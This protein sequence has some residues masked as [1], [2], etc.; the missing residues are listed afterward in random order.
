MRTFTFLL[1]LISFALV[2]A[3]PTP[4]ETKASNST[5]EDVTKSF[6]LQARQGGPRAQVFSHCT[7]PNTVALTF[8]DGPYLYTR[9]VAEILNAAG[10][11]GTF[12]VNGNNW[13][14]IYNPDLSSQLKFAYDTG[15]Q[16]ASH[17]WAHQN[18]ATLTWDQIHHQMWLVEQA[19]Q[20]ITGASVAFMRPPYGS[21]NNLV[22]EASYIRGQHVVYWDF[23]SGDSMGVS[24]PAQ[25]AR[26][27]TLAAT[28]PSTALSLQHE[29]HFLPHAISRLQTAGYNLVTVAQCLG[30]SPYRSVGSPG[31][32]DPSWA[33]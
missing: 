32:R 29:V 24:V 12:F 18:L 33:C 15:H 20:R 6:K 27:D 28:H 25:M 3:I 13:A 2:Q 16:I 23:D 7:V 10:A 21:Y 17:T 9:R 19:V 5:V 1:S 31:V 8:D 11:K 22:L 4:S 30:L 14:C 26:Y